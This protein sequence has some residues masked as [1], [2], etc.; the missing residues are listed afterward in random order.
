[1]EG[2]FDRVPDIDLSVKLEENVEEQDGG[3]DQYPVRHG[4]SEK[5][6]NSRHSKDIK[7]KSKDG[8]AICKPGE[9]FTTF[10]EKH[11]NKSTGER[12]RYDSTRL[13]SGRSNQIA[14]YN[15]NTSS[16]FKDQWLLSRHVHSA[17]D[18]STV[19]DGS[20][21]SSPKHAKVMHMIR[22]QN[23]LLVAKGDLSR[24]VEENGRLKAM[25]NHF[26]SE[27]HK[28]QMQMIAVRQH[29]SQQKEAEYWPLSQDAGSVP[30]SAAQNEGMLT[31]IN[32]S[33]KNKLQITRNRSNSITPYSDIEALQMKL[34]SST[35]T[36]TPFGI[37][38]GNEIVYSDGESRAEL[39][40]QLDQKQ[41]NTR[42]TRDTEP[43]VKESN[44]EVQGFHFRNESFS[45]HSRDQQHSDKD[46]YH[47]DG[48]GAA[49]LM[50][51]TSKHL[52][53]RNHSEICSSPRQL[54]EYQRER[55][56]SEWPP[57]NMLKAALQTPFEHLDPSLRRARVSVRAKSDAPTM[58]D[59]CQWRK[60]GQKMAKGN[61]CPRAYYRC[62]V[63]PGCPVRKQVQRCADDMS[64]LITTY[65]GSHNH[66][67]P[68][69]A[70]AMASTTAAA[71]CILLS[72]S[73]TSGAAGYHAGHM[74][75]SSSIVSSTIS[76]SSAFPTITLDLTSN[77]NVPPNARP[78]SAAPIEVGVAGRVLSPYPAA[79][80][81]FLLNE[82]APTLQHS[83]SSNRTN[84][85]DSI[86]AAM[87][88]ITSDPNFTAALA[89]AITSMISTSSPQ[90]T[91]SDIAYML[92][93]HQHPGNAFIRGAEASPA[94]S[95]SSSSVASLSNILSSALLSLK[96]N[97]T[98][99]TTLSISTS[100]ADAVG[101]KPQVIGV[102][103]EH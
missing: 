1:M 84:L 83:E 49:K 6:E 74:G 36:P 32:A 62:T 71:A 69:A 52:K 4:M 102:D 81:P 3:L 26:G 23:E 101:G 16:R 92:N 59:G 78:I 47:Y 46:Q 80:A 48:V 43:Q 95:S 38:R 31:G 88:S 13:I 86:N 65:E 50:D 54:P 8:S 96:K 30:N 40:S 93:S 66:P 97:E 72:G 45:K 5:D 85:A 89:A 14:L 103:R 68:A 51:N 87:A 24:V 15:C 73:S 29:H 34:E 90:V 37:S 39:L 9:V 61:P 82:V 27:Y 75:P 44:G 21:S 60:Y 19:E 79:R 12:L 35:A 64:I 55:Q 17:I 94:N 98:A 91:S 28:L 58:S 18:R 25:L 10:Q 33:S 56:Q 77:S 2:R 53:D 76:G 67:L 11:P 20:P 70:A 7:E 99:C 57:N 100:S 63:A 42:K 41:M 22:L